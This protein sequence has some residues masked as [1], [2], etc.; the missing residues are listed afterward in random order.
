MPTRLCITL[1][2]VNLVLY[3][4]IDTIICVNNVSSKMKGHLVYWNVWKLMLGRLWRMTGYLP[5]DRYIFTEILKW[6][7]IKQW[8]CSYLLRH[9][10]QILDNFKKF[11]FIKIIKIVLDSI[12]ACTLLSPQL[13]PWYLFNSVQIPPSVSTIKHSGRT[14]SFVGLH[15]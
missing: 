12:M 14:Q 5:L 3:P 8:R 9:E 7:C 4:S 6:T 11:L 15:S 1:D 13:R 10:G 2:F